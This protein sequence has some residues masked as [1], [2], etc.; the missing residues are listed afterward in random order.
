MKEHIIDAKDMD[1][2]EL[3]RTIKEHA[4]S[5]DK[6]I[7]NNPESRHNICAGLTEEVNIE[8]NGSAGYFVGTMV[9]GSKIHING[10]AGWFAGDNMTEGELIIEGTAG[11]GA[12]QG[13]YGGTVIVKGSTGSRTGEIMKGGTVIIGGNS[14]YMT[15]LLMMGGKLI[16][17]GDVTDDVGESI[18]RGTIYVLGNVKSLG[19]NAV[20]NNAT[21]DDQ[22][23]LKEI[24]TEYGFELTDSDYTNFKKIVNM[25]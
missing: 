16:I 14:G 17:L 23:E 18:M 3:N 20:M 9:N 21:L 15:G 10:N 12:G 22:K 11:D 6:L 7:I 19:K 4:V 25:Q 2:K 8:I 1:E 24:L 13:I 5:Y